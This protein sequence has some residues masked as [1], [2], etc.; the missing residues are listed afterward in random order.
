M[1]IHQ[2]HNRTVV[3]HIILAK[4]QS[5][6]DQKNYNKSL[7]NEYYYLFALICFEM[8]YFQFKYDYKVN[9]RSILLVVG[10]IYALKVKYFGYN[11]NFGSSVDLTCDKHGAKPQDCMDIVNAFHGD[12][13]LYRARVAECTVGN[14]CSCGEYWYNYNGIASHLYPARE[15]CTCANDT[16]LTNY[17]A[18]SPTKERWNVYES[19]LKL[20]DT[21]GNIMNL[22]TVILLQIVHHCTMV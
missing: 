20:I 11:N 18:V 6:E 5:I 4:Q 16:S 3:L 19:Q 17:I 21:S 2:A 14:E 15:N 9:W 1:V 8:V 10:H 12:N 13:S 7:A 22:Q